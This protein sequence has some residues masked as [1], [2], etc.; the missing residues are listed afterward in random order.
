ML[1]FCNAHAGKNHATTR[2]H[3]I[4]KEYLFMRQVHHGKSAKAKEMRLRTVAR[5][6]E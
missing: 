5:Q 4:G 6:F 1:R 2:C 3:F